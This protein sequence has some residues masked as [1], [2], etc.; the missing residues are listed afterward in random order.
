M[1]SYISL[2]TDDAYAKVCKRRGQAPSSEILED[3]TKA[4]WIGKKRAEKLVINFHGALAFI[5]LPLLSA[6]HLGGGYVLPASEHMVE[7]MFQ[8]VDVLN[9]RGKD[10]A[11]LF[12]AYDLAPGAVYPRQLQQAATLLTH[13]L[14]TLHY[15]PSSILVMGDSAGANLCMALLS[16][17]SHP[18][19][20][21]EVSIP[22]VKLGDEKLLGV[23]LISPWI[24]FEI[25]S[26]SFR[27]NEWKDCVGA[28]AGTSWSSAFLACPWP[29]TGHKDA[30]NEALSA[31]SS[32]WAGLCVSS[33][34]VVCGSEEVLR[35]GIVNFEG[36][37]REGFALAGK[38]S[39][40]LEFH[41]VKGEYHDQ[42][43]IDLQMGYTERDEGQT[44]RI[45]KSWVGSKL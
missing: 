13:V 20:S 45:V 1:N 32:W 7:F 8:V 43:S 42:P 31:P 37:L 4:H 41:V 3:G 10:A 21:T 27:E 19:P 24:S 11:C 29:H 23:V 28:Q 34:L 18:H 14:H 17:I 30:Y 6:F 15:P 39:T 2:P 40:E 38:E 22:K 33:M 36:N 16:H 9:N 12:L 26:H 5:Y 25:D 44:A 35:D